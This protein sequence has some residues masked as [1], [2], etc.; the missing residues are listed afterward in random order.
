MSWQTVG[1]LWSQ[2]H[3]AREKLNDVKDVKDVSAGADPENVA[4]N[5]EQEANQLR[6]RLLINYSPLVKYTVGRVSA[7]TP[8]TIGREDF[9][10]W[11]MFGLLG[12]IENFDPGREAKFE[13]YALSKIR[14]A[15]LD[16]LRKEDWVPRRVRSRAREIEG[17]KSRLRQKLKRT[18]TEKEIREEAGLNAAEYQSFLQQQAKTR[19]LSLEEQLDELDT[20]FMGVQIADEKSERP[21]I[22][23]Q[24]E[25]LNAELT[26]AMEN[27]DNRERLVITLYFYEG[28]TLKEIG[29]TLQ[30]TEGR[31][32]QILGRTLSKL[33]GLV[34]DEHLA[35]TFV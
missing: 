2:Y 4:R 10:S 17:A 3:R 9:M 21:E 16:E 29:H 32:S 19:V 15:I 28:L 7:R 23:A 20:A 13:T 25:E 31:I 1:R 24:R 5:I 30:V 12:A 27:L 35:S 22:S 8:G 14:W 26:S 6:D 18:P 34:G 33:R 11:G